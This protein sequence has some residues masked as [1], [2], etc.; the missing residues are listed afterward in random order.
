MTLALTDLHWVAGF[1]EGEGTFTGA[2]QKR[3]TTGIVRSSATFS[4]NAAQNEVEPLEKLQRL[5]GGN[6]YRDSKNGGHKRIHR[7]YLNGARGIALMMT[8]WIL[9]T[10]KRQQQ[11]EIC[12][13]RFRNNN[14]RSEAARA[15]WARERA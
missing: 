3:H 5:F 15:R 2:Y 12:I 11:I 14:T 9:M 1:L 10:P 7:W 4:V 13:Q 6:L 8:L